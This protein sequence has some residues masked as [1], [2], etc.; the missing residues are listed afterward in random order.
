[1]ILKCT[2][3]IRATSLTDTSAKVGLSLLSAN[4]KN[5]SKPYGHHLQRQAGRGL[6]LL[7]LLQGRMSQLAGL[8]T[9]QAIAEAI[10]ELREVPS[11]TIYAHIMG[12]VDFESFQKI[13]GILKRAKLIEET[14]AHLLRWIG[15]T[16]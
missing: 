9:V 1:M 10:R 4:L 12:K 13:I 14:D 5:E 6:G 16:I 3:T 11:G 8:Q 2:P 7:D 15:P